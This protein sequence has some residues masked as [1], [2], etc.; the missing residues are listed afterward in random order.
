MKTKSNYWNEKTNA[1]IMKIGWKKQGQNALYHF[2]L[3]A[4]PFS[5]AFLEVDHENRIKSGKPKTV[6]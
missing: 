3:T 5:N 2:I 6:F 1:D 4:Q